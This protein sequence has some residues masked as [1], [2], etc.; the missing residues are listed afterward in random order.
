MRLDFSNVSEFELLPEGT[1]EMLV[2]K[3]GIEIDNK[4]RERINMQLVVRNDVNQQYRNA[5]FFHSIYKSKEPKEMDAQTEGYSFASLMQ[6]AMAAN[7]EAGKD[8]PN[9][10]AL[11]ADFVKRPLKV[12]VYHDV[13]NDKKTARV[14]RWNKTDNPVVMHQ[15]KPSGGGS[16]APMPT[17]AD[18]PPASSGVKMPW[19]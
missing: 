12:T 9:L 17:D 15:P 2:E 1:Y 10:T 5:K 18:A 16:Y 7:L 8:Y 3:S 6:I 11:L 4:Q 19:E 13:Y 14:R